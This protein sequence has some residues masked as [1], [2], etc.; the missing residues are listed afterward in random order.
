[1]A[2]LLIKTSI[3]KSLIHKL[4]GDFEKKGV[5]DLCEN[6]GHNTLVLQVQRFFK[7]A[8]VKDYVICV[9]S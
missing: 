6:P 5:F 8:R 3:C 7:T 9:K 2:K 1:M 4:P